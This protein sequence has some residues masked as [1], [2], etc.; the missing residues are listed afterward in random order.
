MMNGAQGL[1]EVQFLYNLSSKG[2]PDLDIPKYL[3]NVMMPL[4]N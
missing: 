1:R 3:G 2:V 4:I